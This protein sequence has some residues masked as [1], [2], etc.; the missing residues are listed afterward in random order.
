MVNGKRCI[1]EKTMNESEAKRFR[2]KNFGEEEKK[3][4]VK[5][6]L[7]HAKIIENK[8]TDSIVWKEKQDTWKQIASAFNATSLPGKTFTL[9]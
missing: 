1:S 6:V 7:K 2:S 8:A 9:L 3:T 4:L 5:L